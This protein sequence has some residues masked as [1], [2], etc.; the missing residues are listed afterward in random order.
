LKKLKNCLLT[1]AFLTKRRHQRQ[2]STTIY[3]IGTS[4]RIVF[5]KPNAN[6]LLDERLV[7]R[8]STSIPSVF[9]TSNL[10]P[11]TIWCAEMLEK[12]LIGEKILDVGTGAG[13]L[14]LC[15]LRLIMNKQN[16]YLDK[17]QIDAFDIYQD[18]IKQ[19]RINLRLN[20][21]D[22]RVN[23][24]QGVLANYPE[25]F[26]SVVIA[27]LPPIAIAEL[28]PQLIEKVADNGKLILSGILKHNFSSMVGKLTRKGFKIIDQVITDLWC[29]I[30]VEKE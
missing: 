6:I 10:H 17:Y 28:W 16:G 24:R 13:I 8:L 27:N 12:H 14:T 20:G 23:L 30:V 25:R 21:L 18:A 7:I 22:K 4:L 29:L 19:A 15:A 26:Y 9:G 1:E 11:T 3:D 5:A 2:T